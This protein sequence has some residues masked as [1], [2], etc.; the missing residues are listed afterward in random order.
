MNIYS[1]NDYRLYLK[2]A[3]SSLRR[4]NGNLSMREIHRRIGCTSP[5][6]FKEV[7]VDAKKNMSFTMARKVAAFLKL[8]AH[9]TEYFLALVGYNQAKTELERNHFYDQLIRY[10]GRSSA[11]NRFLNV[12][13]HAYLSSW[14]ISAIREILQFHRNFGNRNADERRELADRFLPKLTDDQI[15]KAVETLKS[16]GF[17][18][19]DGRGNYRKTGQNLRSV[20]KTPAAYLTLCQNMKHALEIINTASPESRLFKNLIISVSA[21]AYEIIEN[22]IQEFSKEIL[23]IV[24]NDS[25]PEERLYSLGIQLFPLTKLPEIRK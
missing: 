23:D 12:Q 20:K 21:Q 24:S 9:E 5:S 10:H 2:E 11:D 3:F 18:R 22:R 14:E 25:L 1:Y 4:R 15:V 17:I 6:Y 7:V 19:K 16:L 13:E 8:D